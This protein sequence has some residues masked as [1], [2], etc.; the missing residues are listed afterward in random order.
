MSFIAEVKTLRRIMFHKSSSSNHQE[1]INSFYSD[2]AEDYDRFRE[3]LLHGRQDFYQS[4]DIKENDIWIEMGGGTGRNLE[5]LGEK[6]KL[7]KKIY[8]IDLCDS[9]L[10]IA[11]RRKNNYGW[12]NV[13]IIKGDATQFQLQEKVDIITFS[14]SLTMIPNW[15]LA[16]EN[17]KRLLK[18]QG[19]MNV[20]DFYVAPQFQDLGFKNHSWW[21]RNFWPTWFAM[22]DVRIQPEL[23]L[24]LKQHF[25]ELSFNEKSGRVPYMGVFG[26]VPFFTFRGARKNQP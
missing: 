16:L 8:I 13:E 6:I 7:L 14:Y 10:T 1:R 24:Y 20:I 25:R 22:D 9:L 2:Q 15:I 18:D 21:T 4:I 17:A 26:E 5:F 12:K 23:P 3:K 19:T 11:L